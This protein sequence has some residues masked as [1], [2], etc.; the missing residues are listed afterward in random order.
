MPCNGGAE[1]PWARPACCYWKNVV[2]NYID[3]N[4]AIPGLILPTGVG[5][6]TA[7][8]TAKAFGGI[9]FWQTR[10]FWGSPQFGGALIVASLN[11]VINTVLVGGAFEAGILA[12]SMLNAIP[13]GPDGQTLR[14]SISAMF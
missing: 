9:T 1:S 11:A 5:L 6:A 4:R 10:R 2:Q 8:T 12:G 13:T 7:A 3:T 14:G